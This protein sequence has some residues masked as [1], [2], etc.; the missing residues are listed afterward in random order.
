MKLL[1][2]RP[3]AATFLL[4]F[5]STAHGAS[6]VIVYDN[7]IPPNRVRYGP[8][9]PVKTQMY[10]PVG[11]SPF[12]MVWGRMGI[13]PTYSNYYYTRRDSA[14][15]TWPNQTCWG[16]PISGPWDV[17]SLNPISKALVAASPPLVF[18]W[19]WGSGQVPHGVCDVLVEWSDGRGVKGTARFNCDLNLTPPVNK[20][21][22]DVPHT[23]THA[24]APTGNITSQPYNEMRVVCDHDASVRVSVEDTKLLLHGAG[25]NIPT[26]FSLGWEGQASTV[27]SAMPDA[28]IPLWSV[29]NTKAE[30][31]GEYSGSIILTVSWD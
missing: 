7:E 20:C 13:D 10:A 12:C 16:V 14:V 15:G 3:L 22:V 30:T 2:A 19:G 6:A 21:T 9:E 5:V 17:P 31:A 11:D 26:R 23:I 28:I 1:T 24:T 4:L 29:I 25:G 8:S 27:A 18:T